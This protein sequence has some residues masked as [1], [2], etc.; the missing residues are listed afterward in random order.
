MQVAYAYGMSSGTES[1]R[2]RLRRQRLEQLLSEHG[3]AAQ[4]ARETG[5]P[6]SHFS[7]LVNATRGLGDTL[8]GKLEQIYNKP[9]GWF[10]LPMESRPS[11]SHQINEG[12]AIYVPSEPGGAV[13]LAETKQYRTAQLLTP[14]KCIS[15]LGEILEKLDAVDRVAAGGILAKLAADPSSAPEMAS[16][17]ER[18][19]GE[20]GSIP[21]SAPKV[22]SQ[23]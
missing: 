6:K 20:F 23:G 18:L 8:A 17:F 7:A 9:T 14:A 2:R 21:P 1:P 12:G 16:K 15:Y 19:L 22:A 11:S 13:L 5:T 10:D 4:V 3:G